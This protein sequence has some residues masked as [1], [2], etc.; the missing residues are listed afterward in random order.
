MLSDL[1]F[2]FLY[3][4]KV[5]IFCQ[6]TAQMKSAISDLI[7]SE[8]DAGKRKAFIIM[9]VSNSF[10]SLTWMELKL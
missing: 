5:Y 10:S 3:I 1:V 6:N 7:L 8:V 9:R 2:F 4:F